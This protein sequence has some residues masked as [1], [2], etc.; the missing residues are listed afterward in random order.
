MIYLMLRKKKKRYDAEKHDDISGELLLQQNTKV[1]F[2]DPPLDN[3]FLT[4]RDHLD[5]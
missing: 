3:H 1:V 2:F 4:K 5:I